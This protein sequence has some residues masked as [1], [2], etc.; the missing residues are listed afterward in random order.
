MEQRLSKSEI[1]ILKY[2]SSDKGRAHSFGQDTTREVLS[3][4][5]T[6]SSGTVEDY[7]RNLEKLGLIERSKSLTNENDYF[8]I[9]TSGETYLEHNHS[10]LI[11]KIIWSIVV[12]V[13]VSFLTSAVLY[14]VFG[15]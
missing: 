11:S 12:P 2:L 13:A 9:T 3:T 14:F 5:L 4:Q 8:S 10:D 15:K 6:K 7:V 1:K